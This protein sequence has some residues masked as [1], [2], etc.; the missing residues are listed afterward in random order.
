M[1]YRYIAFFLF[2]LALPGAASAAEPVATNI[3]ADRM[4][5]DAAN[6][7]VIFDGNVH[8]KRPD[9]ELWGAKLTVY[10]DKSNKPAK[11]DKSDNGTNPAMGSMGMDA[12]DIDRIVAEKNVRMQQGTKV[13]T[14]GKATYT[15]ADGKVVMEDNPLIVD[16][17]NRIEGRIINFFTRDNR[18]EVIGGVK[19]AF[20]TTDKKDGPNSLVP[21]TKTQD[22]EAT[23]PATPAK[24][25]KR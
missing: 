9:F 8:V 7:R 25:G 14:A 5:Y 4:Q 1:R 12:G 21:Q 2:L 17:T 6:Q 3:Q 13:G 10:L 15:T 22:A 23:S 24:K 16:G 20:V 11:S 19:A 18:S